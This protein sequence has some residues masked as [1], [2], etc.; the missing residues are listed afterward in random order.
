METHGTNYK[1]WTLLFPK[2]LREQVYLLYAFVRTADNFVD[3]TALTPQASNQALTRMQETFHYF[4]DWWT[5]WGSPWWE[6]TWSETSCCNKQDTAQNHKNTH[7]HNQPNSTHRTPVDLLMFD[8]ARLVK[9]KEIPTE[10]VDSFFD[11]MLAD[12][13]PKKSHYQ[14]YDELKVYMHGSAE[15]IWLMMCKLI[16]YRRSQEAYV[17]KTA[18]QLWE[19]MQYTNFLRDIK[20]DRQQYNRIYIPEE[21]L[22]QFDCNH[23]IL[24]TFINGT[25]PTEQRK[26][27]MEQQIIHTQELY[28]QAEQWIDLL[29]KQWRFS[30]RLAAATYKKILPNI[31]KAHYD[32]FSHNTNT[33]TIQKFMSVLQAVF[34]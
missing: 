16:W 15:V 12:T 8:F 13:D 11:A 23:T 26:Q 21:S 27:R 30:V 32:V 14:T 4:I 18:K 10:R 17:F 19:A 25:P 1:R 9:D 33:T 2:T 7:T 31:R 28:A 34:M 22:Q 3:T 29:D 24:K 5:W 20:E 6:D